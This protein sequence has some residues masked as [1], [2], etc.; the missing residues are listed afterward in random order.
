MSLS[1]VL[2]DRTGTRTDDRAW[3]V[4]DAPEALK[5]LATTAGAVHIAVTASNAA[6]KKSLA[7]SATDTATVMAA[8]QQQQPPTVPT[9][10]SDDDVVQML[11]APACDGEGDR[12]IVLCFTASWCGPCHAIAPTFAR[13]AAACA[14]TTTCA[15]VD[16]DACM[17]SAAA[18]SITGMPTFVLYRG[19][20]E[21]ARVV[22][23][24]EAKLTQ[25]MVGG[26]GG[27][28]VKRGDTKRK[29][30]MQK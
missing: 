24:N 26:G 5:A 18:H 14:A 27:G 17:D 12:T 1:L 4:E 9:L 21:L 19:G 16:V 23:A 10:V 11:T 8:K 29:A 15:R 6:L 3:V 28:A 20:V 30:L 22:G 7:P 2:V 25:L 13:L